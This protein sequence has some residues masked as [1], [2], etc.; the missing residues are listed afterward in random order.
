MDDNSAQ[1]SGEEN[2]GEEITDEITEE[3]DPPT[4]PTRTSFRIKAPIQAFFDSVT[5][6]HLDLYDFHR[7]HRDTYI[8]QTY[9]FESTGLESLAAYYRALFQEDF[10][11]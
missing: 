2:E 10:T 8:P 4:S 5:Q 3:H 1:V 6:E 7:D 9:A 11:L